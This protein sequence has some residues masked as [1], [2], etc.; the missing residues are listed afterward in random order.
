[1]RLARSLVTA[2]VGFTAATMIAGAMISADPEKKG[3]SYKGVWTTGLIA[4]IVGGAYGLLA[5]VPPAKSKHSAKQESV[6]EQ[7]AK[8]L[9]ASSNGLIDEW[10]EWRNFVVSRKV[11]ESAEITS[12]YLQPQDGGPLPSFQPGQFLTIKLDIPGQPRPVIRTYSL[13]DYGVTEGYYRLS[14]KR[15]G[16]PK[17]LEVPP[18]L[19]SNFMHE[20][21]TEGTVIPAKPPNGKFALDVQKSSPAVLISNGVGITPMISMAKA[22]A[23]ENPQRHIWFLHGARHGEYH[24]LREEMSALAQAFPNLHIYYRYSRPRPEDEGTYHSQGYVD[25]PMLQ[26]LIAPEL[27]TIYGD[28]AGTQTTEYFLCGSPAFM[29][30]LRSGLREWGVSDTQVFFESFSKPKTTKAASAASETAAT[31]GETKTVTFAKSGKTA[32]W[33]PSD[34]TLLEFAEAQGIDAPYSCRA[35]ICL[36]CM[37]GLEGG[38]VEYDEPP[39]GTP[40]DGSVL[41]CVSKPKTETVVIDL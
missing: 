33:K 22:V 15:E 27:E 7:A 1:M 8:T 41:I 3:E 18:G 11:K 14:I 31:T 39:T 29:D 28:N 32:T 40:D 20:Q 21:V 36:T 25:T 19:A 26:Q 9:E 34:G 17:G 24:A 2:G 35:G 30:S 12:F 37:C 5:P 16:S 38:E 13:S 4:A 23:Q 6:S 10:K